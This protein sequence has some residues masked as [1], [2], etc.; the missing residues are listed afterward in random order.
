[1]KK[2]F[3]TILGLG[4]L[5]SLVL[6]GAEEPDGSCNLVWTLGFLALSALLGWLWSKVA[7]I[8]KT[9]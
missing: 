3:E 8:K 6:A 9:I 2:I 4:C 7:G 5:F 1:M